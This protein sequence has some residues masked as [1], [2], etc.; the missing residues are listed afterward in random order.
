MRRGSSLVELLVALALFGAA[1]AAWPAPRP[2]PGPGRGEELALA[3]ERILHDLG[4]AE[5]LAG[6]LPGSQASPP[7]PRLVLVCQGRRVV[8]ELA[9][10]RLIR[11]SGRGGALVKE[12]EIPGVRGYFQARRGRLGVAVRIRAAG[13]GEVLFSAARVGP[14]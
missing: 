13:H 14:P 2:G 11:R 9:F 7:A 4:R 1:L 6:P 8:W 12:L 5:H 3:I 10:G